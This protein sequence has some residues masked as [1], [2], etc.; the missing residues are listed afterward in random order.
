MINQLRDRL[1]KIGDRRL[2]RQIQNQKLTYLSRR[3]MEL[4]SQTCRAIEEQH[5]AGVFIEAGCALG[6]SA[7]LISSIKRPDR[8]F[9]AYDTFSMIPPPTDEDTPDVHLRYRIISEG[10]S[11]GIDG[12]EYYGYQEN[13]YERVQQNFADFGLDCAERNISLIQGLLQ[14]SMTIKQPVA[15]AHIDVD[16]YD[17]VKTCLER[18][19]P[20]LIVGGSLILDDYHDWGG[21]R[22]AVDTYL[23]T[24]NG[25]FRLNDSAGSLQ[26][27]KL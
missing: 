25:E 18:I 6:G 21:C 7:I 26:I 15:F 1:K 19:F 22:K 12:D 10:K 2:I 11:E 8:P 14:E 4:I 20:N 27:I 13:L 17:P 16:W 24:V 5:L 23:Q 3:K 9:L